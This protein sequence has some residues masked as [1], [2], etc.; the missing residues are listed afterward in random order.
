MQIKPTIVLIFSIFL[1]SASITAQEQ[2]N[3]DP[4]KSVNGGV[5]N[6]KATSLPVPVYPSGALN[7]KVSVVVKVQV[8][9]DETGSVISAKAVEGI[10]NVSMRI[11]A[12][13]AAMLTKFSPTILSGVPVKVSGVIIYKFNAERRNEEILKMMALGAGIS[14]YQ[15]AATT[16]DRE[17]NGKDSSE[18]FNDAAKDLPNLSK[19]LLVIKDVRKLPEAERGKAIE[20]ARND[21]RSKLS[22]EDQWQFDLGTYFGRV[23]GKLLVLDDGSGAGPDLSKVDQADVKL[24]MQK[25]SDMLLS[26]SPDF[27]KDVLAK[28]KVFTE[29]TKDKDLTLPTN[30]TAFVSAMEDLMNTIKPDL[31]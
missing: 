6:G 10:E 16:L 15:A 11:A 26:A 20:S 27:P 29:S 13:Q 12:E 17:D 19:E 1:I 30:F 22:V 18:M 4:P 28:M 5:V 25:I 8:L 24:N 14:M 9:I 2:K 7:A 21:I 23:I 31:D 3:T